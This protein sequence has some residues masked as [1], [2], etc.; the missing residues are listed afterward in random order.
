MPIQVKDFMSSPVISCTTDT[1]VGKVRDLMQLKGFSAI[2]VV[3]IK[4]EKVEI[5]GIISLRD[6]AGVYDDN[7]NVQ[8]LMT[9]R[10]NVVPPHTSAQSA[11]NLMQRK[12]IHHLVVMEDG[13]IKG[14]VSA[15]DFVR[16]VAKYDVTSAAVE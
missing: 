5:R 12:H 3:N 2:P 8:Q 1:N 16:L 13:Q 6:L 9:Q 11:A 4:G 7:V 10:V 14:M 15:A